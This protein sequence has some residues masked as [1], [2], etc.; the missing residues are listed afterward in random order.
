MRGLIP[1]LLIAARFAGC[2]YEAPLDPNASPIVG[3]MRGTLLYV[4]EGTVVAP[5]YTI[6]FRADEPSPPYGTGSPVTFAATGPAA[7]SLEGGMQSAPFSLTRL[8]EDAYQVNA[9]MDVDGNFSPLSSALA[10]ATCGD[11]VGG[12]LADLQTQAWAPVEVFDR[13]VTDDVPVIVGQE[14]PI[15]R[16]SFTIATQSLSLSAIAGGAPPLFR[17]RAIQVNTAFSEELPLDLGP[18]CAPNPDPPAPYPPCAEQPACACE[19]ATVAPCGTALWVQVNDADLD[20][21]PDPHP[22]PALA[23]QGILDVW[24]RVYLQ[25]VGQEDPPT[26]EFEGRPLQERWVAQAFPLLGEVATIVGAG[27]DLPTA[28]ATLG[29]PVGTPFPTYELSVTFAP[30]LVH[31]HADGALVGAS[32]PYDVVDPLS[33]PPGTAPVGAWAV[34]VVNAAGQTWTVPNE[35]GLLSLP[36]THP[37]FDPLT[38]GGVLAILE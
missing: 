26:Y 29:V 14:I 9:L 18:V 12:H 15:E 8:A 35:I 25:Y 33:A 17:L 22:D 23:Q 24:P 1:G 7:W 11:I 37:A 21:V 30:V 31:Y 20:G 32:G 38:Q 28:F 6:L 4:G 2:G 13:H 36:S 19:L 5:T 3:S 10:G 16:P 34:T 27:A